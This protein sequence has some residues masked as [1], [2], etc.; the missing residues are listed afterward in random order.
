MSDEANAVTADDILAFVRERLSSARKESRR[1]IQYKHA[2]DARCET[3][4][5]IECEIESRLAARSGE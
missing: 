4:E 2:W 5:E 1:K 3:L